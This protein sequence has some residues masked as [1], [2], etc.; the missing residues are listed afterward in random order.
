MQGTDV[1]SEK[2]HVRLGSH[3]TDQGKEESV[4][5]KKNSKRIKFLWFLVLKKANFEVG[6]NCCLK[7]GMVVAVNEQE[8]PR[9]W[10]NLEI[11]VST[12]WKCISEQPVGSVNHQTWWDSSS[13]SHHWENR[14]KCGFVWRRAAGMAG[15]YLPENINFS[16]P[17]AKFCF[18]PVWMGLWST[19]GLL[20]TWNGW[21]TV[22]SAVKDHS[23]GIFP[24]V[25]PGF[26]KLSLLALDETCPPWISLNP[27]IILD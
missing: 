2:H 13:L 18:I 27:L 3:S 22:R 1:S 12:E 10:F 25:I 15:F 6:F 21:E 26:P 5:A 7:S 16:S 20:Q 14:N 11:R 4:L 9:K 23:A 24:A 17:S 8:G 19:P